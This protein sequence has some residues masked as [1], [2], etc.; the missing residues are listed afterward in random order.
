MCFYSVQFHVLDMKGTFVINMVFKHQCLHTISMLLVSPVSAQ[1]IHKF[2]HN[3]FV[4]GIYYP[5]FDSNLA[6]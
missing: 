6:I 2:A 5:L 1:A 4:T 3:K